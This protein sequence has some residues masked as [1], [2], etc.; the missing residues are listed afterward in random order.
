MAPVASA[1]ATSATACSTPKATALGQLN[2]KAS[3][4]NKMS[5]KT[6]KIGESLKPQDQSISKDKTSLPS[7]AS[8]NSA[9]DRVRVQDSSSSDVTSKESTGNDKK[10][11]KNSDSSSKTLPGSPS[12]AKSSNPSLDKKEKPLKTDEELKSKWCLLLNDPK[13]AANVVSVVRVPKNEYAAAEN[14]RNP[15]RNR[16]L[17]KKRFRRIRIEDSEESENEASHSGKSDGNIS[18]KKKEHQKKHTPSPMVQIPV[19]ALPKPKSST[20]EKIQQE[21]VQASGS[22]VEDS[23]IPKKRSN[24]VCEKFLDRPPPPLNYSQSDV[25]CGTDRAEVN[26]LNP[27]SSNANDHYDSDDSC[28]WIRDSDEEGQFISVVFI[29][30]YF[31]S[32]RRIVVKYFVIINA[33]V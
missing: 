18:S 1:T 28:I 23:S 17:K 9:S 31:I 27:S 22:E 24:F 25:S 8:G 13:L 5:A 6:T 4:K 16:V 12:K 7:K 26:T 10:I 3:S 14:S 30:F 19:E 2:S 29:I 21:A 15:V 11:S 20:K 33:F 32:F